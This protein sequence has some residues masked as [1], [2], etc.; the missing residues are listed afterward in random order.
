AGLDE[1]QLGDVTFLANPRYTPRVNTTKASA[2]YLSEEATTDRQISILRAKD[3]YLAY[4]RALRVFHP[5]PKVE[6]SIHP[7]AVVDPTAKV[8]EGVAIGARSVIGAKAEI[9]PGVQIHPNATI[10]R[11]VKIGRDSVI[12]SGVAIRERTLIGERVIVHNNAVI[13]CDGF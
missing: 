2:I 1:A 4:T 10:Y 6:P 11:E 5:E 8:S 3:P 9:G 13:G 7:S 12:H